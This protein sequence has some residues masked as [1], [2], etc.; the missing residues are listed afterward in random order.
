MHG[1]YLPVFQYT[2]AVDF[3]E[4]SGQTGSAGIAVPFIESEIQIVDFH[5]FVL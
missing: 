3:I 1:L 4:Q 2:A 5:H